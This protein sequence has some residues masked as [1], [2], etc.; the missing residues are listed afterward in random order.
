MD[1][2][3]YMQ[4]RELSWLKF[5]Q[6]VLEESCCPSTPLLDRLKFLSIFTTNLDEFFMV[7][8]G[9]LMDSLMFAPEYVDNK[10]GMDAAQQ[11]EQIYAAVAPLYQERTL[12]LRQL[13]EELAQKGVVRVPCSALTKSEAKAVDKYFTRTVL[14]VLSPQII[15]PRH[16]FP[17]LSNKQLNIVVHLEG[18]G[19][20]LFGVLPVPAS[21]GRL[22]FPTP[23]EGRFVVIEEMILYYADLVFDMYNVVEKTVICVTRNADLDM[24]S[25]LFDEDMDYRQHMKKLLKKRLRLAPVRMEL[26]SPLARET[27]EFL[28]GRLNLEHRQVYVSDAPLDLT[29]SFELENHLPPEL[30][31][32]LVQAPYVPQPSPLVVPGESMI[33]Q[34]SQRDILLSYPFESMK[35]FLTLIK[36]AAED[37][38]VLSIKITLYRISRQS[39]LAQ[40]L[41]Q[42]AENGKEVTVLMELRARFDEQNNIEWA[43]RLEEAGC[44]M[45]YGTDGFKV[46]S[47]ICLI[48]RS[49]RGKIQYITQIGTGNY[50][51]KTAKL[52]TDLCLITANQDIGQDAAE[53]F[54]NMS[55]S[56]LDGQYH[57][58]L[59][60]P[61][62]F[63]SGILLGIDQEIQKAKAGG[64]G[65]IV[66]KCNSLTDRNIIE[67]LSDASC[68]GVKVQLIV[69]GICCLRPGVEGATE[70]ITIR[71]IVG[72]FL[73]HT[74]I[75]CFGTGPSS[76]VYISSGDMMTRNTQRRVEIACP[77][78]DPATKARVL[79]ILDM[80]LA[81]NVKARRQQPDGTYL[82]PVPGP[83]EAAVD[84]QAMLMAQAMAEALTPPPPLPKPASPLKGFWHRLFGS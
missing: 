1:P 78:Y 26:Y 21:L 64:E 19:K 39:G 22:F 82:L 68:A 44:R 43:Q 58:L 73:E 14:P 47:K 17:H 27:V 83:E 11:L 67:R 51:E 49:E 18:K 8:V 79:A 81:D 29:Y 20:H 55:L 84:S 35:P 62:S 12:A 41:I 50:N 23:G 13:G 28:C 31:R 65:R 2:L 61:V 3:A 33:R 32:Q 5:N 80:E 30:R 66:M 6:R 71:S 70:N 34:I 45:L 24:D 72:H 75:Y 4:N 53:F 40:S 37:P 16:P 10:T 57:H 42:A 9:S 48:T 56:N 69:R 36:E 38:T 46:H 63:K 54:T 60:A 74:R 25:G 59:V 15:D 52:Y 7:R 77:L 76:R